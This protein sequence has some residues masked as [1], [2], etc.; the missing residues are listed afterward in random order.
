MTLPQSNIVPLPK[1]AKPS[2]FEGTQ[3]TNLV[4]SKATGVLFVK[5]TVHGHSIKKSLKTKSVEIG[6]KRRDAALE[7]AR[8]K[9]GV[10]RTEGMTFASLATVYCQKIADDPDL[11][12]SSKRYRVETVGAIERTWPE[13]LAGE[14]DRLTVEDFAEWSVKIRPLYSAPRYNAMLETMRAVLKPAVE[15]GVFFENP[16]TEGIAKEKIKRASVVIEDKGVP[17][18]KQLEALFRELKPKGER[19]TKGERRSPAY[20][21]VRFLRHFSLRI[22]TARSLTT[23]MV[24]RESSE[25]QIPGELVKWGVKG[26]IYRVPIFPAMEKVLDELDNEYG[27]DRQMVLPKNFS[28]KVLESACERVGISPTLTPHSF[29]H[30]FSTYAILATKDIPLVAVWRGDKDKGKTLLGTYAHLVDDYSKRM[31]KRLK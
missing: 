8:R 28:R 17:T 23:A 13:L 21:W 16:I 26:K 5:A 1:P 10:V 31:A 25:F 12:D 2:A 9:Y 4:R 18:L 24:H 3:H 14:I 27:K 29:R 22:G 6:L 11:R 30:I 20:F 19:Y 15:N 7:K